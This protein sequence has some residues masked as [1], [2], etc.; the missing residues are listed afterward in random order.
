MTVQK[1]IIK[2]GTLFLIRLNGKVTFQGEIVS[3]PREGLFKAQL[4]SAVDGRPTSWR[5]VTTE[6][7]CAEEWDFFDDSE[8]HERAYI[9]GLGART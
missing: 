4:F 1:E 3:M 6:K 5:L 7:I 9:T 8:E 2:P